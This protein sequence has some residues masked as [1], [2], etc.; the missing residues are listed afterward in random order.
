MARNNILEGSVDKYD[1]EVDYFPEK[2]VLTHT[3][4]FSIEYHN[5]YKVVTVHNP[6]RGADRK[7]KYVLVQ[8][9]TPVPDG[10]EDAQMIEAPVE[11]IVSLSTTCLP[12]IDNLGLLDRLVGL[13]GFKYVNSPSVLNLIKEEKLVEVG[14]GGGVNLEVLLDLGPDLVMTSSSGNAMWDAHPKLMEAGIKVAMNAEYMDTSPLSRNEWIKFLAVFFNREKKAEEIFRDVKKEYEK[15]AA[16]TRDVKSRP[17][18]FT[19]V[20]YNGT[21]YIPGG[22]SYV[23]KF[24]EDAG[25]NYIWSDDRSTG[26]IPLDFEIVFERAVD[27]DFWLNLG[28]FNNLKELLNADE[29]YKLF[30]AY[31]NGNVYNNVARVNEHGGNDYWE[32]GVANPQLV[33]SDIIKIIHP[34]LL[35]EHKLIWYKKLE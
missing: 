20:D 25:A 13:G 12:Y 34:E 31:K 4:G 35:P 32:S 33:L 16:L 26:S 2:A 30:A 21:W 22:D 5:H 27:A 24:L 8:R 23:A 19:N 1:P 29:R 11:T 28:I 14:R 3:K 17:T 18:V 10:Y 9:G 15:L 6:W 7:F